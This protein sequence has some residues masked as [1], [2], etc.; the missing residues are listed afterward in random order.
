MGGAL[1][2][3]A[4][5]RASGTKHDLVLLHTDDIPQSALQLLSRVWS[6]RLVDFVSADQNLFCML[7]SRFEGVFTKLHVL[8]LTEYTKVLLLDLDIAVIQCP[9]DLFSLPAPAA[10]HRR[11]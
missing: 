9:D 1:V 8:A 5:L 11:V 2:L 3:G 10:M 4:G 7:G 6:L